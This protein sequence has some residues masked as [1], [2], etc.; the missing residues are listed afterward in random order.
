MRVSPFALFLGVVFAYLVT[1]QPINDSDLFWHVET[2]RLTL[3]GDLPRVEVFSWTARGEPVFTDQWLGD[4]VLAV[5]RAAAGWPG[6]LA[7]RALAV[8]AAQQ[9]DHEREADEAQQLRSI[10]PRE[11]REEDR[12]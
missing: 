6:I 8:S 7:L 11:P 3:A 5:A 1:L 9:P 4:L 12:R 10:G 2:G